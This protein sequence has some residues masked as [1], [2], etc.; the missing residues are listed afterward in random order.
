MIPAHLDLKLINSFNKDTLMETLGIEFTAF[1]SDFLEAT[2]P[3]GKHNHQPMGLLHGGASIALAESI[4]S[5]GSALMV[6]IKKYAVVG[7]NMQANHLKSVRSGLVTGRGELI[8]KGRSTHIWDITIRD[9]EGNTISL[10]R[11]T[12]FIKSIEP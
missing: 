4:G 7:L 5:L 9:S 3:V 10:C 8:H 11:F 12:N 1:G 2:M 6:D